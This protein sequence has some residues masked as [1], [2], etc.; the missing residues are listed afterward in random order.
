MNFNVQL[1]LNN[2]PN[3]KRY[4][5]E[6]SYW[7]KILNRNPHMIEKLKEEIKEK[8]RLRTT[9]KLNNALKTLELIQNVVS[10]LK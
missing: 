1:E 7:Y 6:N 2:N 9:D 4:V 8:Y 10:T 3:L 5:R